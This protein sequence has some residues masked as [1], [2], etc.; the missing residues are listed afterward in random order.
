MSLREATRIAEQVAAKM[1]P[2]SELS[3]DDLDRA[4]VTYGLLAVKGPSEMSAS[5]ARAYRPQVGATLR[6]LVAEAKARLGK[7]APPPIVTVIR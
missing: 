7:P 5:A 6:A 4:L 1:P 2:L 3:D